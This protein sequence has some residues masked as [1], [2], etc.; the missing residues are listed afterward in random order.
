[1]IDLST[2]TWR[3]AAAVVASVPLILLAFGLPRN[4]GGV[5]VYLQNPDGSGTRLS[6]PPRYLSSHARGGAVNYVGLQIRASD[7]GV[8][9]KTDF[10]LFIALRSKS[11]LAAAKFSDAVRSQNFVGDAPIDGFEMYRTSKGTRN[12]FMRPETQGSSNQDRTIFDCGPYVAELSGPIL[13]TCE[14]FV[15]SND[16]FDVFY[17]VPRDHMKEWQSIEQEVLT[18]VATLVADCFE[19]DFPARSTSALQTHA[20]NEW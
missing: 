4:A 6:V 1:M 17:K 3:I 11:P 9:D 12:A 16:R 15:S 5:D 13:N 2:T 14:G 8:D 10:R 20:C 18:F 19:A 7:L